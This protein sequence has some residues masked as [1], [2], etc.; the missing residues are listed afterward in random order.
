MIAEQAFLA[1][2]SATFAKEVQAALDGA[3]PG[4]RTI[5]SFKAPDSDRYVVR[6]E[7]ENAKQ[8]RIPIHV[9]GKH[10]ADLGLS[11]Y[12]A[13]DRSGNYL[14]TVRSEIV[15]HSVLDRT[16]LVRLDYRADMQT[17]PMSHW[18]FHGERGSFTHLLAHSHQRG[19]VSKPHDLSSLHFPVGGERFRPCLEDFLQFLVQECGVDHHANWESSVNAGRERWRRRQLAAAVRDIPIE[20]ARTLRESGWTVK[21]PATSAAAEDKDAA[22]TSW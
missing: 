9:E 17:V 1:E 14:K 5:I 16:P 13:L 4:E 6:P 3:L 8:R 11:F 22:L 7:G 12:L 20:A 19:R 2:R 18:Q 21:P 10:L 15:L